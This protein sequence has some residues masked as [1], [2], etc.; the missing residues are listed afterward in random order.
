MLFYLLIC[1]IT[2]VYDVWH[3]NN[4][5]LPCLAL[6]C[7]CHSLC[8]FSMY[9]TCTLTFTETQGFLFQ[10]PANAAVRHVFF[11][12]LSQLDNEVM[13][14]A[15]G[16]LYWIMVIYGSASLPPSLP[17]PPCLLACLLGS[18]GPCLLSL[19]QV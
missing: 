7:L 11:I 10:G 5:P 6:P 14:S 3:I 16:C 9:D 2:N 15:F 1:K 18:S 13:G 4:L 12:K 8:D 17:L 19:S